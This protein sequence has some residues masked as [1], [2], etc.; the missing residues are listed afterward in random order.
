MTLAPPA[1]HRPDGS[2]VLASPAARRLAAERGVDL[3]GLRG[4]GPGGRI[5]AADVGTSRPAPG[6]AP[7]PPTG[8][9]LLR[10][11][12]LGPALAAVDGL[13]AEPERHIM[14]LHLFVR[15][16]GLA[17]RDVLESEAVVAGHADPARRTVTEIAATGPGDGAGAGLPVE[18]RDF[19]GSGAD[20][21]DP[22]PVPDGTVV[23]AL[24]RIAARPAVVDGRVTVAP[25]ATVALRA[26]ASVSTE[27]AAALLAALARRIEAP[28]TL[29]A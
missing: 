29:L 21:V 19:T 6:A 16:M 27:D 23:L 26:P 9:L 4:S 10:E 12:V 5:V 22:G 18:I 28:V 1:P 13:N 24:G 11:L 8:A 7:A 14:L 15:A 17:V 2:R 3:L 25:A 20:R